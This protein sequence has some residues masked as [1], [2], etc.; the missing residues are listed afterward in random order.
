[1]FAY[2]THAN[3]SA[4]TITMQPTP[5]PIAVVDTVDCEDDALFIEDELT[6]VAGVGVGIRVGAFVITAVG[7]KLGAAV[8]KS[9]G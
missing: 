4:K 9:V 2:I 7:V 6:P 5:T 3:I 1:L 8:G